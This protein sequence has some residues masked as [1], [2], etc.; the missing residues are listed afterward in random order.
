MSSKRSTA[1]LPPR[2]P[3]TLPRLRRDA[4]VLVRGPLSA[5]ITHPSASRGLDI[6]P[7]VE[8]AGGPSEG[9]KR[10]RTAARQQAAASSGTASA[11]SVLTRT[12]NAEGVIELLTSDDS[13]AEP[14]KP[15]IK[16]SRVSHTSAKSRAKVADAPL[17]S[18]SSSAAEVVTCALE[19]DA[20]A[21]DE[22]G[23]SA[24]DPTGVVLVRVA[25]DDHAHCWWPAVVTEP[26]PTTGVRVKLL[27]G[28]ANGVRKPII[29]EFAC[30]GIVPNKA[31]APAHAYLSSRRLRPRRCVRT[32]AA[33]RWTSS[34]CSPTPDRPYDLSSAILSMQL[35]SKLRPCLSRASARP[36]R[37]DI[38]RVAR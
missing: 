2:L 30:V 31:D 28:L 20:R 23:A 17:A 10:R 19:A 24:S 32:S 21:V 22:A 16:R 4:G 13:E 3:V 14:S 27:V 37:V 8:Y 9:V 36:A 12:P 11:A 33:R 38:R 7:Q 18:T 25:L 35:S 34:R 1:S 15:P 5:S 6:P 29:L 26:K